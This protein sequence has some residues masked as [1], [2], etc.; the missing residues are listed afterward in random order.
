MK[1]SDAKKGLRVQLTATAQRRQM[2]P[3]GSMP[4]PRHAGT[5]RS[6]KPFAHQPPYDTEAVGV[7]VNWDGLKAAEWWNL[8]DLEPHWL[9]A[10]LDKLAT[11]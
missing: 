10:T 5:I 2:L 11:A 8:L 9:N 4:I 3:D 1:I 6:P 7:Y